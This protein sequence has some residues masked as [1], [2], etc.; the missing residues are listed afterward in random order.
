[1]RWR[2]RAALTCGYRLQAAG[3]MERVSERCQNADEVRYMENSLD[4]LNTLR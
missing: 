4:V 2:L 3:N 1:M